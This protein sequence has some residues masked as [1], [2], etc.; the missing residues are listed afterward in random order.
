MK[1]RDFIQIDESFQYSINIQY[2]LNKLEKIKSYIPTNYLL[3]ILNS[4]LKSVYYESKERATVLIGPYGKGKSH[5][6]LILMAIISLYNDAMDD[7]V[8]TVDKKEAIEKLL[9]NVRGINNETYD[10]I[11]EIRKDNKKV[12]PVIINSNYLDLNQSFLIAIN[13][14]LKREGLEDLAPNTYFDSILSTL[15]NWKDNYK[16]TYNKFKKKV[17][18]FNISVKDF[19]NKIKNYDEAAYILFKEIYPFITSGGEF[20]PLI[21]TDVVKLYEEINLKLCNEKN[22]K[23]MFIVFDEFSK[24]LESNIDRNSSKDIKILQDLA[25]LCSRSGKNQLHLCCITHKTINDYI[26]KLPKE[27]IDAWRAVEGRFKE[28]YFTSSSSQNYELISNAIKKDNEKLREFINNNRYKFEDTINA[29]LRV[30]IFNDLSN[31]EELIGR[32]CFPLNPLVTYS[33]PRV[34]EKV[35]QN[36]RTLFT[37]LSKS[38]KGSLV[39]FIDKVKDDEFKILTLD[40]LYDY[41]EVLFKKETFNETIHSMW[42]K[43]NSALQKVKESVEKKI[44]KAI[45][46]IYIMN[47]LDMITPTDLV[48][49]SSL[50]LEREEYIKG[51]NGLLNKHILI[52]KKSNNFYSFL[53]GSNLNVAKV[54]LETKESKVRNLNSREILEQI[55][56]LGYE[57]PKRYNDKYEMMRFFKKVFITSLELEVFNDAKDIFDYYK[58]D[59][60]IFYGIYEK[61]EEKD[62][63]INKIKELNSKRILICLSNEPFNKIEQLREYRAIQYLKNDKEFTQFDDYVIQELNI[64]EMDIVEDILNYF[65]SYYDIQFNNCSYYNKYDIVNDIRKNSQLSKFISDICEDSFSLTPMINNEMINKMKISS[66][67]VKARS[68]VVKYIFEEMDSLNN[69]GLE[70]NGPEA[71]IFRA[72]IKN[73][74]LTNGNHLSDS[75]FNLNSILDKIEKFILSSEENKNCFATIYE[76]LYGEKYGLRSGIIPIYMA[77]KLKDYKENIVIYFIDKG[78]EKEVPLSPEL[79]NKLNESPDKYHLYLEKGTNEKTQYII[80][81]DKLFL[82][83]RGSK[84]VGYNRFNSIV[85]SMQRWV[86]SLPKYTREFEII[87]SNKSNSKIDKDIKNF[88]KNLMALEI[89]PREFIF[90]KLKTIFNTENYDDIFFRISAIKEGLESHID[91][92]KKFII[93]ESKNIFDNSYKG[94]L[95]TALYEWYSSLPEINKTQLY[96]SIINGVLNFI[97]D[98][99][100]Y[101]DMHLIEKLCKLITDLNIEDWNDNVYDLYISKLLD[102]K[103]KVEFY[104]NEVSV[105][106]QDYYQLKFY[107]S[108]EEVNKM[109]KVEEVSATGKALFNEVDDMFEEYADSISENEKRNILI[110]LMKRFM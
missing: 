91:N 7:R 63:I 76:A 32:E 80:D 41:F 37:F 77:F 34:S 40:Y 30:G 85:D 54:I 5:L 53:P 106:S 101:D 104:R 57:L 67:I 44:L 110:K 1:Y 52:K 39:K 94:S 93:E 66:P 64:Y 46:I 98:S 35:A 33:L 82:K 78:K 108:G 9:N 28:V 96:D 48:I 17:S 83:F 89:N 51:I 13:E 27:K 31:Y 26:S 15:T 69:Q 107:I 38:E 72:T 45:A 16:D 10:L 43:T 59:G 84:V 109:F 11:T 36:E 90:D 73:K 88:R 95:S 49:Q 62:K 102:I 103:K 3:E 56:D 50:S 22:Y 18:E 20:N 21:N 12:L 6:L 25:E 105:D 99:D 74:G 58:S 19:I 42:I 61:L 55:I 70:G 65:K 86:Q 100:T 87:Y 8:E 23:G 14:A 68:K 79:L 24:F 71:T 75:D 60:I 29:C 47:E 92:L 81:L 97:S 4:Y 2:D